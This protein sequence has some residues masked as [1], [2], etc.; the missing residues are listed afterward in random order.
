MPRPCLHPAQE[1]PQ[2]QGCW[3]CKVGDST[4]QHDF[5]IFWG[6]QLIN[7]IGAISGATDWRQTTLNQSPSLCPGSSPLSSRFSC[8][9]NSLA[10][11]SPSLKKCLS[12]RPVPSNASALASLLLW[13]SLAGRGTWCCTLGRATLLSFGFSI[14]AIFTRLRLKNT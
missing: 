6:D 13:G 8:S 9:W 1:C 14:A 4:D 7:W 11:I 2:C 5:F 3:I 12:G 10:P